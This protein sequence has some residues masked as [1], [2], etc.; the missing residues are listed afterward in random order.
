MK[1]LFMA[2]FA[3]AALAMT[4]CNNQK[5]PAAEVDFD[6]FIT[7]LT[8]VAEK[9][10]AAQTQEAKDSLN[11]EFEALGEELAAFEGTLTEEQQAALDELNARF[12]E[13]YNK[14][15]IPAAE[16]EAAEEEAAEEPAAE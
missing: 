15:E 10:E 1:K 14:V 5:A 4:S 16:E 11:V 8:A 12:W 2:C 7:K 3:V 6:A 9:A 13:A